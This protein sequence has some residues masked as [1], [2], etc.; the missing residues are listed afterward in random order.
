MAAEEIG[1]VRAIPASVETTIPIIN[2]CSSV[3]HIIISPTQ[4]AA[5]ATG[6]ATSIAAATP[7]SRVMAGVTSKSTLV[8]PLTAFPTSE[9]NIA[10]T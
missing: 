8:S 6:I 10:T 9:A 2:G 1:K 5:L 4:L 7:T 3:P